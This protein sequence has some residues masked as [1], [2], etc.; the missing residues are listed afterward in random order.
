MNFAEEIAA[1]V[2]ECRSGVV[3]LA[4][5]SSDAAR[6]VVMVNILTIE[7]DALCAQIALGSGVRIAGAAVVAPDADDD[8]A[9]EWFDTLHALLLR[10]SAAFR[11]HF[12]ASVSQ[13]LL[14]AVAD[15]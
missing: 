10:R 1:L 8:E 14:A 7:G 2:N 3:S 13:K 15:R 4:V 9:V 6:L 11:A 12:A 5:A